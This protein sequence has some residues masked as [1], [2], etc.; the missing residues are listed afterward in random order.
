VVW[1]LVFGGIALAGL[2]MLVC[3]GVW[4]VHK[5]ADLLSEVAVLAEQ[6]GELAGLLGQITAPGESTAATRG[7]PDPRVEGRLRRHR[8]T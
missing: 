3:Y 2:V 6:G 5:A 4:L 1:V 8:P 7:G